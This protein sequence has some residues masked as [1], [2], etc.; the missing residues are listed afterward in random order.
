M[1]TERVSWRI[2]KSFAVMRDPIDIGQ[3]MRLVSRDEAMAQFPRIYESTLPDRTGSFHRRPA[4]WD[5]RVLGDP[6]IHN[7]ADGSQR[8]VIYAPGGEPRGYALYRT[9]RLDVESL[10]EVSV[11]EVI[12]CD[13]EAEKALWQFLFAI[14][15]VQ[16]IEAW[17]LSVNHL[18]NWWINDVRKPERRLHDA[19]WLRVVD[20]PRALEGRRYS[21][22][23]ELAIKVRDQVCSWNNTTFQLSVAK[24]GSGT[25]ERKSTAPQIEC[26]VDALG[27][28]YLAGV[29]W[30]D[31]ARAGRAS[32]SQNSLRMADAMFA[33]Y[34]APW[35]AE[36]F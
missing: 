13:P 8:R 33:W 6:P 16:I 5:Q 1:A 11:I 32:G 21:A 28:A 4:W 34:R 35:C 26:D 10:L 36:R 30:S 31:L 29:R 3:T 17:N 12:G 19:M 2:A 27:S 25:C 7:P 9:R 15:Y 22:E 23:G 24:N 20:V 18:L 14:D